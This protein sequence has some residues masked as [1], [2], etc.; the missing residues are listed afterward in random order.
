M[1]KRGPKPTCD[2][3]KFYSK[4]TIPNE[5]GCMEWVG[6]KNSN[7]Y[8]HFINR[9]RKTIKAHRYSYQLSYGSIPDGMNVLHGCD[10]P[11]CVCPI[12]L[13][14]GTLKENT[15]DC[16]NKGRF[17]RGDKRG[18]HNGQ[19]KLN[20]SMVIEI[21][22]RLSSGERVSSLAREIGVSHFCISAIKHKKHGVIYEQ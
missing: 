11:L 20:S 4:V 12:H 14:L 1:T 22:K 5:N 6:A 10:N 16:I 13:F 9:F 2:K 21:R 3:V 8:G 7:G 19:H 15:H 18:E 17:T